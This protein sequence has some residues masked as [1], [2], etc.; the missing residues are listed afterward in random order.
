VPTHS[1]D[2]PEYLARVHANGRQE[3]Q[4]FP[5]AESLYRRYRE[6]DLVNGKPTPLAG[7]QFAETTGHSVNR[8]RYSNPLDAIEPDCCGGADRPGHMV[9]ELLV[10][11]V[12]P[13]VTCSETGRV[14]QFKMK[15]VPKPTCYAHSEIW[16]NKSGQ[17]TDSYESPPKNVKDRFRVQLLSRLLGM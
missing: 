1:P 10:A 8:E 17:T 15:H 7:F 3:D 9:L 4:E 6:K 2:G 12:P 11:D 14:Y 16:C 5:S 13:S